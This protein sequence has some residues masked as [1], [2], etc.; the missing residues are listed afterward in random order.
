MSELSTQA[1]EVVVTVEEGRLSQLSKIATQLERAGLMDTHVLAGI[2][3]ITG[4]VDADSL[5]R[6]KGVEGVL[7]VEPSGHVQIAP[8]DAPIQ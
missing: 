3:V 4:R 6:L 7:A 5:S 2:G 1:V 8:P